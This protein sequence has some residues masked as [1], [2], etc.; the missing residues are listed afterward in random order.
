MPDRFCSQPRLCPA[1]RHN[2]HES[3]L[4]VSTYM[5]PIFSSSQ[6]EVESL[7]PEAQRL[8]CPHP[9]CGGLM[10]GPGEGEPELPDN[11]PMRCHD[12]G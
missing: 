5:F 3:G 2:C 1:L 7:I 9:G 12:C 11:M 10:M 6:A 4:I 8:Y